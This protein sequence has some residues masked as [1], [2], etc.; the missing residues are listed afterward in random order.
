[1]TVPAVDDPHADITRLRERLE[2]LVERTRRLQRLTVRLSTALR[3]TEVAEIVIGESATALGASSAALW[4]LDAAGGQLVLL[5]ASNYPEAALAMVRVIALASAAPVAESVRTGE[6]I[7]LESQADYE[8]R[9]PVS[10]ARTRDLAPAPSYS[11]AS[12]PVVLDGKVLGAIALTF[13]G[14]RPFDEDERSYL[15]YLA[16]HCA[17]GF[18][19]ARLYEAETKARQQAEAARNRAQFLVRASAL[20]GSSLDYEQTLRNVAALAVPTMADWCGV[21][22]V[23]QAG[24][25]HQV[26]VAHVDPAKIQFAHELRRRYPPN[27][28]AATGVPNVLRTGV[29]ELYAEIPDAM[30]VASAIDA[31]HLRITRELG[32]TSAMAVPIKD[33]DRTVGVISFVLSD[34]RRYTTDDITMA[35][36]L[37]ERAGAAIANAKLYDQATNAIR[38]RDEFLL[39]AGHELRT[40]LA[41]LMLQHQSLAQASDAMTI[42][43]VREKAKKLVDQGDRLGRLIEELLDVSRISAGQLTLGREEIDL[44]KLVEDIVERMTDDPRR[45]SA[46]RVV[47][48]SATGH[49]DRGRLDQVVTNLVSNAFK[50]GSGEQIDVRVA[51]EDRHAVLSVRDRGIGIAVADQGRIFDRFERAVSPRSFGGLGLGLWIVRQ[52]VVAHG[53]TIAVDSTPGNGSTFTVRLPIET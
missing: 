25:S 33:R 45:R 24:V 10:E 52:L 48:E 40:P 37:G 7:W 11:T 34:E 22:L 15:L 53:G 49:W 28:N 23:D 20:L 29:S 14:D 16:V 50:Y 31:E 1:M 2:I 46:V 51:R 38:L 44:A 35:E 8:A 21:D 32:L 26:A 6:A 36:Q 9:Y 18:D 13:L 5:G 47:A 3:M 27:P 41:V 30:L 43:K 12:L 42:S 17:Q 4:R 19:R 39:I